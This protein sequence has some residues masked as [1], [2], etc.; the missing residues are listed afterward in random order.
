MWRIGR[1]DQLRI[2][3]LDKHEQSLIDSVSE[4]RYVDFGTEGFARCEILIG[5]FR[6]LIHRRPD[7]ASFSRG[8]VHSPNQ[9]LDWRSPFELLLE[10]R[11]G[12][13][14]VLHMLEAHDQTLSS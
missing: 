7:H 11:D 9:D 5:I 14:R 2:L 4:G 3:D 8:W 12:F 10:G 6:A 13:L 1:S